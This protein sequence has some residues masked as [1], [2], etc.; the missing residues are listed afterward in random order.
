MSNLVYF[1]H[2]AILMIIQLLLLDNIQVSSY[3]Y[4]NIYVLAILMA[5]DE[6]SDTF[7]LLMAFVL[8]VIVDFANNT[9]GIH[10][11]AATLMAYFRPMILEAVSVRQNNPIKT[12]L[13]ASNTTWL[14]KYIALTSVIY[15]VSF[16]M[17][18]T[19]SFKA[20]HITLLRIVFSTVASFVIMMLY[21]FTA[22]RSSSRHE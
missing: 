13:R 17:L 8:G 3:V 12:A 2:T 21:Y 18:E 14:A 6:F 7:V 22:I 9:M 1:I 10:T 5:P 4:L 16:I 19:F 15:F 20:F 11:A